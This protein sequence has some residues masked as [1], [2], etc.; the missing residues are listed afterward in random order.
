M[1]GNES[2][3]YPGCKPDSDQPQRLP[4]N[5]LNNIGLT[6]P[7]GDTDP[8]FNCPAAHAQTAEDPLVCP[9]QGDRPFPQNADQGAAGTDTAASPESNVDN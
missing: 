2:Q 8:N 4:Q 9:D 6:G 5:H 3:G 1:G 7:Q